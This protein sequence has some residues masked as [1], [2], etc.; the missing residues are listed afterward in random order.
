MLAAERIHDLMI[1]IENLDKFLVSSTYFEKRRNN[2][3]DSFPPFPKY[4]I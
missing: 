1:L 3:L 4:Y 2:A